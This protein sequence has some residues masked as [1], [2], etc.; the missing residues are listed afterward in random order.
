MAGKSK[1][2]NDEGNKAILDNFEGYQGYFDTVTEA[3]KANL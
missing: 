1:E 2:R 3:V